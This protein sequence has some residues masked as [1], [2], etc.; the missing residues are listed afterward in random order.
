MN[1]RRVL[2]LGITLALALTVAVAC[3]PAEKEV[4]TT[5]SGLQYTEIEEGDGPVPEEGDIVSIH[6]RGTLEDGTEFDET[7]TDG[8]PIAFP[9]GVGMVMPGWDEGVAMMRVGGKA[10]LVIP[11]ELGLGEQGAGEI[12]PPNATLT[13]E[14]ELVEIVPGSPE[15]PREVAD[16]DF[17]TTETG[18]KYYDFEV[19][20]GPEAETGQSVA[21]HYTGWLEDGTKFDSSLDRGQPFVFQLGAGQVIRG[22]DEGVAGMKVG[23]QRQLVIPPELGYGEQGAGGLIPPNATLVF[24]VELVEIQ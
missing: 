12:I 16:D 23:G 24:E 4:V 9:L 6:F 22:W 11:P 19:G 7:Y 2:F 5:E 15:A 14:I 18:L 20:E 17:V 13:F 3:G 10:K 8:Q 1:H 21:V